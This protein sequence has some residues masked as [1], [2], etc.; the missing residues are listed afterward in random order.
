MNVW[1]CLQMGIPGRFIRQKTWFTFNSPNAEQEC[2]FRICKCKK[3]VDL[4]SPLYKGKRIE[5]EIETM[6]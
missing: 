4:F 2:Y 1:P 3:N 6:L 5:L